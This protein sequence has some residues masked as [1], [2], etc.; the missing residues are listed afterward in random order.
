MYSSVQ[1]LFSFQRRSAAP[2]SD[3]LCARDNKT[4]TSLTWKSNDPAAQNACEITSVLPSCAASPPSHCSPS[5]VRGA[6]RALM[7]AVDDSIR[8]RISDYVQFVSF[9]FVASPRITATCASALFSDHIKTW[10]RLLREFIPSI[11]AL[12]LMVDIRSYRRSYER[13]LSC[14]EAFR[15]W[16]NYSTVNNHGPK[17]HPIRKKSLRR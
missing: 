12:L 17:S 14:S 8:F 13:R 11:T 4:W 2:C 5:D 9:R 3:E 16:H 1:C 15:H 10:Y 6:S 7:N